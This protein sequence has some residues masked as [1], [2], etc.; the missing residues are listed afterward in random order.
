[1]GS[2]DLSSNC[3]SSCDDSFLQALTK[4]E[5]IHGPIVRKYFQE[6]IVYM[7]NKN[8]HA[9]GGFIHRMPYQKYNLVVSR[10]ETKIFAKRNFAKIC[11][12]SLFAKMEK[13]V[14]VSTLVVRLSKI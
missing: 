1:L 14:F 7:W 2:A 12:F 3:Y 8:R 11:S 4:L 5:H 10:V 13:N 6:G 9:H